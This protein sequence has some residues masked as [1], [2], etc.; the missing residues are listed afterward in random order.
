MTTETVGRDGGAIPACF[1]DAE[2]CEDEH[3]CDDDADDDE[4]P[5]PAEGLDYCGGDE[6]DEVLSANEEHGVDSETER[7]FV[8][9]EN[10]QK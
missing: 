3:D 8:E 6:G 9:E 1:G 2:V 7:S 10:L 5:A 4:D